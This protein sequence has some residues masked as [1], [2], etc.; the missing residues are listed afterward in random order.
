MMQKLVRNGVEAGIAASRL[1]LRMAGR[2]LPETTRR[3]IELGADRAAAFTRATVGG[4]VRDTELVERGRQGRLAVDEQ[5]RALRLWKEAGDEKRL[6]D[7]KLAEDR[8]AARQQRKAVEDA[9]D[10]R[11]AAVEADRAAKEQRIESEAAARE[12]A[13]QEAAARKKAEADSKAKR[14]RLEV[15]DDELQGLR[16]EADAAVAEDEAARLRKAAAETKAARKA[17]NR[18]NVAP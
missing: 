4:L 11:R 2:V 17:A 15:L 3:T 16:T 13:V 18:A 1:P 14:A 8:S 12:R 7:L 5:I 10:Q 6:A 9:A